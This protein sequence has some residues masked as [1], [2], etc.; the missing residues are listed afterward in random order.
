MPNTAARVSDRT[1]TIWARGAR[2]TLAILTVLFMSVPSS[3]LVAQ[4][5]GLIA[6][7]P[8]NEAAG[9]TAFDAAGSYTAT[10]ASGATWTTGRHGA[11]VRL[12]GE[13]AYIATPMIDVHGSALTLAAWVNI[14]DYPA[15]LDQRIISKSTDIA[16]ASHYWMLSQA[17]SGNRNLL[18]FRLKTGSSTTTLIASTGDLPTNTWYHATATYDGMTMRLYLNGVEVGSTPKSGTIATNTAVPVSIGRSPDGSNFLRGIIDDVRV[19]DQALTASDIAAVMQGKEA[20]P[21]TTAPSIPTAV[22]ATAASPTQIYVQWSASTDDTAVTGYRVRRNGTVVTTTG[23]TYVESGLLPSTTY[24]YTVSAF[25]SAG[26][27]SAP[28]APAAAT[29]LAPDSTPPR[30]SGVTATGVTSSEATITWT[31]DEPASSAV[32]YGPT[33]SYGSSAY[34]HSVVTSHAVRIAPLQPATTYHYRV[35]STDPA[36]NI[37]RSADLAFTTA[38]GTGGGAGGPIAYWALDEGTGMM[39][40]NSAGGESATLA[41]GATWT[42]G[43]AAYAV[44][45]NGTTGYLSTPTLD[46]PGSNMTIAAWVSHSA[47]PGNVEQRIISKASGIDEQAHYWMLSQTKVS[48][49]HRLRFRLRTG[50]VTTTLVAAT[51]DLPSDTWYHAAASYDGETMRL[52]LD[53]VEVGSKAKSGTIATD[54]TVPVSIGRNPD[55]SNYLNGII[56]DVRIYDRALTATDIAALMAGGEGTEPPPEETPN[57]PPAVAL[58]SPASGSSYTAPATITLAASAS[59]PENRLSEV[60]FFSGSTLLGTDTSAPYSFAW[61]SVA[62]GSYSVTARARD[63]DGGVTTSAPVTIF[64]TSPTNQPPAVTITTPSTGATFSALSGIAVAA[65]ASD[66]ENRLTEVQFYAGSTLLGRDTTAP[67]SYSWSSVPAGVYT[68]TAV[69]RD[70]DGGSTTSAPVGITV[71]APTTSTW[72]VIFT[73]SPDHEAKVTSYVLEIFAG[74]ADPNVATPFLVSDLGKPA[75]DANRDITVDRTTVFGALAPGTY[76]MT[77]RATGAGG[78]TR[79]A[80]FT[81]AK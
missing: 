81:F 43:R 14:S 64:V 22:K 60:Q 33:T 46:L 75:P 40:A 25:D 71:S 48:G 27:E 70:A 37:V 54:A 76:V 38:A 73:A 51:G 52:Y 49:R 17:R 12:D 79:S 59:D 36:G 30:L 65:A 32:E 4:T 42:D 68:L 23:T 10:L 39:A 2:I 13:A 35:T 11:G 47:F 53:G 29:T 50:S 6:H 67:Y 1:S 3:R 77:I 45:L 72:R 66:P 56:D 74:G 61:S 31:T 41:G 28:S 16:E 34:D 20:A 57:Q 44:R 15:E 80:A 24:S 69:A 62:A 9:T 78:S 63:A 58:T 55:G 26:N 5:G 18:R 19:Y 7:W 21:D 8:L